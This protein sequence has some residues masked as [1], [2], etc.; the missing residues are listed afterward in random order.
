MFCKM[1]YARHSHFGLALCLVLGAGTSCTTRETEQAEEGQSGRCPV[2]GMIVARH[3]TWAAFVEYA[4]GEIVWFDGVKDLFKYYFEVERF[5][6][7]RSVGDI[8]MLRVTDYYSV[9]PTDGRTASYVQGSDVFGPMG[10]E[11]IPF[12][13]SSS[14]REFLQDHQGSRVLSFTEITPAVIAQLD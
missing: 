4:D 13:D 7:G 9:K 6:R 3:A 2:C 14:A 8:Q 12:E 10:R 5:H 1:Q 11:L